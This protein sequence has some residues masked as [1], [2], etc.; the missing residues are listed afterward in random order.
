MD[1]NEEW[2]LPFGICGPKVMTLDEGSPSFL[3]LTQ[4]ESQD[5]IY[6]PY[7]LAYDESL[8]TEADIKEH[9]ID[10][11][12]SVP[13]YNGIIVDLQGSFTFE[14]LPPEEESSPTVLPSD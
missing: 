10:Y 9:T 7:S 5:P 14:I 8:A 3:T 1:L 4:D 13:V 6:E 11:T 12:V 2:D